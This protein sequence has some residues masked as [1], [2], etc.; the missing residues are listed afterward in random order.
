MLEVRGVSAGYDNIE[1]LRNVSLAVP[2]GRIIALL[3][4]NGAGKTTTLN[5]I[6]GLVDVREG[7]IRYEGESIHG[8]SSD[9]IVARGIS[10]VPEGREVFAAMS[11]RENLELGA[12]VRKGRHKI[13]RDLE[14]VLEYF[15]QL[16][17]RN[18]QPA[19]TLSGGEQQ[20]LLIGRALMAA[21][22]L[23]LFDEPSLGL[24]PIMV[25]HIFHFIGQLNREEGL[26]ILLVEQNARLAL[27]VSDHAYVLEN[28]EVA[29]EGA[30]ADLARNDEVRRSYL[31]I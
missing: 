3:G 22:K 5:C 20:M 30:S 7:G 25:Q 31:G 29:I 26:T 8:L 10:Q 28:G 23:L 14:R 2:Q 17:E 12:H 16:R 13:A 18:R 15:P 4:A 24:S 1:A 6:S 27:S 19:G 21:P 11:V 9:R